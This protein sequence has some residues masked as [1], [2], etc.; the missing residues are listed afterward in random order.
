VPAATIRLTSGA[1]VG[2]ARIGNEGF[3]EK[4][5]L[6]PKDAAVNDATMQRGQGSLFRYYCAV[7]GSLVYAIVQ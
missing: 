3:R 1:E 2:G 5:I 4:V 7:L 6:K